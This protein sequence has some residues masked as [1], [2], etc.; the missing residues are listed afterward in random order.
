MPRLT[1]ARS[2][3]GRA[4]G[5]V[6]LTLHFGTYPGFGFRRIFEIGPGPLAQS[7]EQRT[8]NPWVDGSSPSGPT[9]LLIF[10]G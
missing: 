5:G 2:L 1:L 8:F 9:T 3:T 6:A 4:Y 10:G 7:V